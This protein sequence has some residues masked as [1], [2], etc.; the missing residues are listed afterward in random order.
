ML[1]SL[2]RQRF[3]KTCIH[4]DVD[5]ADTIGK[6]W[7]PPNDFK[8]TIKRI[9]QLGV[10]TYLIAIFEIRKFRGSLRLTLCIRVQANFENEKVRETVLVCSFG[11]Q[12][13]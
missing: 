11:T 4:G 2:K 9:K 13:V 6:F 12:Y 7:R 3:R 5:Y 1:L 8:G 10:F